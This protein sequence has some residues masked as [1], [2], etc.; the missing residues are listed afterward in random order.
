MTVT[1][2]VS[3][4]VREDGDGCKEPW[5]LCPPCQHRNA[6][7]SSAG[8]WISKGGLHHHLGRTCG[9]RA[10]E[11]A[12]QEWSPWDLKCVQSVDVSA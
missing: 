11:W 6:I 10:D 2:A 7:S 5:H 1:I 3:H 4:P 12:F 9:G 8:A